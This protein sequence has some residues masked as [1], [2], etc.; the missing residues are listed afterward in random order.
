MPLARV[1]LEGAGADV[2][3]PL[4]GGRAAELFQRYLTALRERRLFPAN[5]A[6]LERLSEARVAPAPPTGGRRPVIG[7][8]MSDP[9]RLFT[10]E[11]EDLT[12]ILRSLRALGCDPVLIPPCADVLFER[13]QG[14]RAAGL[15]SIMGALD[16]FLG[17]GGPDVDPRIYLRANRHAKQTNLARDRFE[18]DLA[19]VGL[20]SEVF[21][22]G[23]CRAHQLWNAASG[24]DM[25]QDL[26]AQ[27][28][29]RVSQNQRDYQIPLT[30]PFVVHAADGTIEFAN[31]VQI[32]PRSDMARV[33][34]RPKKILTNSA[35]HQ[36]VKTPGRPFRAV[37]VVKDSATGKDTIE[38]CEAPNA[39]TVQWHPEYRQDHRPDA[40]LFQVLAR[41]ASI[42]HQLK[43]LRQSGGAPDT[44]AL[45]AALQKRGGYPAIDFDWVRNE[46]APRLRGRS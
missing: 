37:G 25:I 29:S 38:A 15:A 43:S 6:A 30:K 35:H 28:Y 40:A 31:W 14:P 8:M 32:T 20:E 34:G 42:F 27:R 4:A 10:T 19:L 11:H 7:V 44:Q 18:A 39:L 3:L 17:P 26:R 23:I 36:A 2:L 41:R 16:G 13:G 24:G 33:M 9:S 1:A 12:H 22:L 21:M 45:L 5:E 46:L